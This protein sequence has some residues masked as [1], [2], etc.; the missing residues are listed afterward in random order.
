MSDIKL[1]PEAVVTIRDE[2][3]GVLCEAPLYLLNSL[4]SAAQG[5][6]DVKDHLQ[7][8]AWTTRFSAMLSDRF[9]I[10]PEKSLEPGQA[11]LLAHAVTVQW[12]AK[13][14]SFRQGLQ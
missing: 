7:T 11:L 5:G 10:P 12:K 6:V 3:G 14:D 9:S 1:A 2:S 4:V 13:L 8:E